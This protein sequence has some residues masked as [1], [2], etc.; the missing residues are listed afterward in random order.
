MGL[1]GPLD[2][3]TPLSNVAT[4]DISNVS[5]LSSNSSDVPLASQ[6]QVLHT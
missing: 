6:G 5:A 3:F 4:L 2:F 1:K